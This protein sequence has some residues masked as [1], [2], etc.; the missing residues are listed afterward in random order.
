MPAPRLKPDRTALLVVDMQERLLPHIHEHSARTEAV[1]R[2]VRG[3]EALEAPVLVTE[4]YPEG[5]GATEVPALAD[6]DEIT[7]H[8]KTRFSAVIKPI[9]DALVDRGISGV[10]VCGIETHVCVAQTCLDLLD[11]G[12]ITAVATD[13]VGSRRPADHESGLARVQQAGVIPVTVEA[14]LLELVGDAD[15]DGFKAILPL[16]R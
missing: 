7:A 16:I 3:F 11:G 14:A 2:L 9:T 15:S 10:V 5:L 12:W 4:Q 6:H 1:D 13:A 8:P